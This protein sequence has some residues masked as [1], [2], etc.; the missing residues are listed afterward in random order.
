M[1]NLRAFSFNVIA[2]LC[3]AATLSACATREIP[4]ATLNAKYSLPS[5]QYFEPEPGL[6][7]HY[8][9]EGSRS[10]AVVV[11]VH[12]FA[13]SVHAWRPWIDRLGSDYRFVAIDLP[14]HGLTQTPKDYRASLDNNVALVDALADKLRLDRFVLGGNSMGGGVALSYAL[15]HPERLTGLVL[16]D[17]AGWPGERG[18]GGSGPPLVFQLLTNPFGRAVLKSFNPA[19]FATGGLKSAYLDERLVTKELVDRYAEL[20]LAPGHRDILITQDSRPGRRITRDDIRTIQT[21]TLVLAGE[22]DK[23]I[24][25]EQ[26]RSL[27]AAIPGAKLITYPQGGHVPMEQLPDQSAADFK[28]FVDGLARRASLCLRRGACAFV[29]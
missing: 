2:A 15:A 5:S 23:I 7:V 14:G 16:V 25:V 26:S 17:A 9:D 24:P 10:G 18:S 6:K 12:G 27:A 28:A 8:T 22:Q 1:R 20:A 3:L 11:L 13:A 21:P 4:F 29:G 19:M